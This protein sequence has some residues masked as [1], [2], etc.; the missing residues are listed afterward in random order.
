D[1]PEP[2]RTRTFG[3]PLAGTELRIVDPETRAPVAAGETG[4]I[5]VRGP[6]LMEG[7]LKVPRAETF[8]A[9]G[10]FPTRPR[11]PGRRRLPP[12]RRPAEGR[13]QDGGRQRGGERGR[14]GARAPPRGPGGARGGRARP[15]ARRE[16]GGLRR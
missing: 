16:R 3:R 9:D 10:F 14:G 4:E 13:H 2:I 6:T 7:Y 8:D 15:G 12:L 1:D 5:L 11:L